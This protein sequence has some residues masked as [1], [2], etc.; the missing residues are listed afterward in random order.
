MKDIIDR[1]LFERCKCR[2]ML[3]QHD[4][5]GFGTLSEKTVHAVMKL[6]YAPDED[7]HEIPVEGFIAD[8]YDN[9]FITEIQNGNFYKMRDKLDAFLPKYDVTIV[10]PLYEKKWNIWIDTETGEVS[11][12]NRCPSGSVYNAF[13]ELY[14]IKGYLKDKHLHFIFPMLDIE[15][16]RMLDGWSRDRKHGSNRY[17]RIPVSFE[18]E[19]HIDNLRD[20]L[21]FVPYEL[22]DDF[23]SADFAKAAGI[24]KELADVSLNILYHTGCVIRSGKKGSYWRYRTVQ[25]D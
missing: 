10:L 3:K 20:Y 18:K 23:T 24:K 25:A 12:K 4:A 22:T 9:G 17:D 1:E 11:K 13:P 14:R 6:Y 7:T 19:Y 21:Q 5:H 16:Y 8:I 15:E 2:V